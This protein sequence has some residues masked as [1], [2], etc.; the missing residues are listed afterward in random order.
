M[1]QNTLMRINFLP[2]AMLP[3][4]EAAVSFASSGNGRK[5]TY[6]LYCIAGVQGKIRV[7]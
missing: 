1:Q 7:P 6:K 3:K 4:V 5:S 2:G